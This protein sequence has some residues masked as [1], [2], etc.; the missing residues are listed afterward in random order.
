[1]NF[2]GDFED[3]HENHYEVVRILLNNEDYFLDKIEES[4][5]KD[6]GMGGMWI[7]A[8]DITNSFQESYLTESWTDLD[9]YDTLEGF[10]NNFEI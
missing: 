7:L 1:M 9:W 5:R 3:W 8:K 10:V 2:I 6:K 4:E